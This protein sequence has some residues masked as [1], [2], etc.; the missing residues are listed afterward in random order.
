LVTNEKGVLN[1]I[2]YPLETIIFWMDESTPPLDTLP[3]K[4]IALVLAVEKDK[5]QN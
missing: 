2:T 4:T 5:K 1:S 3:Q